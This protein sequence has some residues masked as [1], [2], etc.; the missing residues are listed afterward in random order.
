MILNSWKPG[1]ATKADADGGITGITFSPSLSG[2]PSRFRLAKRTKKELEA[3]APLSSPPRSWTSSSPPRSWTLS[4]VLDTSPIR[5][6]AS[7]TPEALEPLKKQ[8]AR[9]RPSP[10]FIASSQP[11]CFT[12]KGGLGLVGPGYYQ[13]ALD[14]AAW[15]LAASV[16][17]PHKL[18]PAFLARGHLGMESP[19]EEDS[20]LPLRLR[21]SA[22]SPTRLST[23][24]GSDP[25]GKRGSPTSGARGV[26]ASTGD[27]KPEN[28]F[29]DRQMELSPSTFKAE[30]EKTV[31][32]RI[33]CAVPVPAT[34]RAIRQLR[35]AFP[36]KFETPD[37][38]P[39]PTAGAAGA[40][41]VTSTLL[42]NFDYGRD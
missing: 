39:P 27:L 42:M 15:S 40:R 16:P 30:I 34:R 17:L 2:S 25:R 32:Y 28:P 36:D 9:T 23:A 38:Y 18:S 35:H 4:P 31:E 5:S 3:L 14:K 19:V 20:T 33:A 37:E 7:T 24:K 29:G 22:S 10:A 8:L 41:L 6:Q 26:L 13:C 21:H 12:P 11:S 1:R